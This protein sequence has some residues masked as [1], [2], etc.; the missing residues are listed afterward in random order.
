MSAESSVAIP[1]VLAGRKT[2]NA[3]VLKAWGTSAITKSSTAATQV[4]AVPLVLGALGTEQ[5]AAFVGLTAVVSML[6][7]L[8]LGLAGALVARVANAATKGRKEGETEQVSIGAVP[9]T[10]TSLVVLFAGG[11]LIPHLDIDLLVGRSR[12]YVDEA[13]VRLAAYVALVGTSAKLLLSL[14]GSLRQAYQELHVSNLFGV[15]TNALVALGL[16]AGWRWGYGLAWFVGVVVLVPTLVEVADGALLLRRRPYLLG[17]WRAFQWN[18]WRG[19]FGG[20]LLFATAGLT[21]AVVYHWPSYYIL[22]AGSVRDAAL[23]AIL[24]RGISLLSSLYAS[25]VLPLW[26]AMASARASG[27]VGWIKNNLRLSRLLTIGASILGL[28]ITVLAGNELLRLWI[29]EELSQSKGTLVLAGLYFALTSWEYLHFLLLMSAGEIVVASKWVLLRSVGLALSVP[30]MAAHG[31]DWLWFA[32]C[33]SVLFSTAWILP[34]ALA[35]N[36]RRLK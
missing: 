13:Q 31:M 8:N 22:Q 26:A 4:L 34:L 1:D 9:L 28:A 7:L 23:F 20:G 14:V 10:V 2:R 25:T 18:R 24:A 33:V 16:L 29:G 11:A 27:D 21:P 32:M 17:A 36:L 6:S 15:A 3:C 30:I 12:P 35:A 5:F 19:A